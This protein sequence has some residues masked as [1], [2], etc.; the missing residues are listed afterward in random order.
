MIN[1]H[2]GLEY[3]IQQLYTVC[4]FLPYEYE[5]DI[6]TKF[7]DEI[8]EWLSVNCQ[9]YYEIGYTGDH[10]YHSELEERD[11]PYCFETC[12]FP[13]HFVDIIDF[14]KFNSVWAQPKESL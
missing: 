11:E 10:N 7:Q 2:N 6:Q 5:L 14:I 8:H 13:Y 3:E 1:T 12:A 9:F 4:I